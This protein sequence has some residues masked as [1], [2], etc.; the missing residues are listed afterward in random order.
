MAT[1]QAGVLL[2]ADFTIAGLVPFL[3]SGEP[4]SLTATV[5]P[6]DQVVPL[7]VDGAADCWKTS[8][9]IAVVWTRPD[10]VIKSFRRILNYERTQIDEALEEVDRFAALLRTASTRVSALLVPCWT[11][12]SYDRG[13]GVLN[14]DPVVGPA[15][16]L[17]RMNSRLAETVAGDSAIHVLDA[18]RWVAQ[19]G[20]VASSPKLWHLGKI[21]FGPEVFTLAA[22]DI[23]AAARALRGSA[24]KLVIVDLDDTLWGGVV[25]DVGWQNLNLGGHN[26]IGEAFRTFQRSLKRLT[27][28]GIVLAIVSKNTEAIA[29]EAIDR[30]PEMVL[31]RQD[32]VGWRINWDD[33]VENIMTLAVRAQP[34][35]RQR[36]VHR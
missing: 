17:T 18:G 15:Y 11:W 30:H 36:R 13:L 2:V 5:A 4:P 23:K 33:K 21:A 7:L 22:A 29:L 1:H 10:A 31:G 35:P 32:F 16:A 20:S 12:P 8:P 9:E 14:F 24:R 34:W 28:R 19:A 26:P 27:N 3:N 6:F 25:G